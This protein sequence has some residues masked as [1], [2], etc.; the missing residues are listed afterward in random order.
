MK[1]A[2]RESPQQ[3]HTNGNHLGH[4]ELPPFLGVH[5]AGRRFLTLVESVTDQKDDEIHEVGQGHLAVSRKEDQTPEGRTRTTSQLMLANPEHEESFYI[6]VSEE[7][8][9]IVNLKVQQVE[10]GLPREAVFSEL[11]DKALSPEGEDI[12][13]Q[14]AERVLDEADKELEEGVIDESTHNAIVKALETPE[15]D[16]KASTGKKSLGSA[17]V[18]WLPRFGRSHQKSA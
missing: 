3:T 18:R 2:V 16:L 7:S 4:G 9:R 11:T 13:I 10:F 8:G 1:T 17:A 15:V 12:T 14:A 6:E 5:D